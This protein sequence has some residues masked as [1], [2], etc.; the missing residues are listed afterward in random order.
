M[1]FA[2]EPADGKVAKQKAVNASNERHLHWIKQVPIH[3]RGKFSW[4][5]RQYYRRATAKHIEMEDNIFRI[6]TGRQGLT[7]FQPNSTDVWSDANWRCWPTLLKGEDQGGEGFAAYHAEAF[8]ESLRLNIF[9]IWEWSH[10]AKNCMRLTYSSVGVM[11]FVYLILIALNLHHGPDRDQGMRWFQKKESAED[12]MENYKVGSFSLFKARS[13]RMME[14][15]DSLV[16]VDDRGPL[17]CLFDFMVEEMRTE[18]QGSKCKMAEYMAWHKAARKFLSHWTYTLFRCEFL[19]LESDMLTSRKLLELP[20]VSK[21]VVLEAEKVKTTSASVIP[22]ESKILRSVGK[23][24]V[25][26]IIA[27]LSYYPYRRQLAI[28][29]SVPEALAHWAG[30]SAKSCLNASMSRYF[31]LQQLEDSFLQ[32]MTDIL[33]VF[34]DQETLRLCGFFEFTK[35]I[36]GTNAYDSVCREDD[37][38]A[39]LGWAMKLDLVAKR[40]KRL[41]YLAEGVPVRCWR[42]L[43]GKTQASEAVVFVQKRYNAVQ[44]P[45]TLVVGSDSVAAAM[46]KRCAFSTTPVRQVVAGY[47]EFKWQHHEDIDTLSR[48]WITGLNSSNVVELINNKQANSAQL[49]GSSRVRRPERAHAVALG[50]GILEKRYKLTPPAPGSC[51]F[52]CIQFC[53]HVRFVQKS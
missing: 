20:G 5:P 17:A 53:V 32:H 12:I 26:T 29:T 38:M 4:R 13:Y 48:Q 14:E 41:M 15:L 34:S 2:A 21:S 10:G 27:L 25:V 35:F 46:K 50:S 47:K 44:W 6:M 39:N 16:Q 22:A 31:L 18:L 7:Y 52:N 51:V 1:Y 42:G 30:N 33:I 49:K 24:N 3:G 37:V 36:E 40:H 28:I 8:K 11:S 23:N 9:D 43:N 45:W 19:A